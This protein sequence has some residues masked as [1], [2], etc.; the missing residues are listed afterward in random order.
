MGTN[1]VCQGKISL[2]KDGQDLPL[3]RG[4]HKKTVHVFCIG[5]GRD[6]AKVLVKC[7]AEVI[8]LSRTQ[9]D[10]DSLRHDVC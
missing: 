7:G 8:A 10:L 1:P 2:F 5:I 9:S 6:T 4:N 3:V